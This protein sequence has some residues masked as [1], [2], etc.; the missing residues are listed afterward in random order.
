M[1]TVTPI[2][3][4]SRLD[5]FI[6]FGAAAGSSTCSLPGTNTRGPSREVR[7]EEL[8]SSA[9]NTRLAV[10]ANALSATG[11][12]LDAFERLAILALYVWLVA[13]VASSVVHGGT[14]VNV[15]LLLSEGLVVVFL[16][17]R[18][19]SRDLSR[20][21][22]DWLLA[23][24]A[25]CGP[26]LVRPVGGD[27][28]VAPAVA[29]VLWLT[30]TFIQL[31]AKIALGRSFGCVPAHRGIKR[32]GPYCVV[33]HPMYAGYLLGHI[34]FWLLN[35][36]VGNLLLLAL[37][38]AIQIPRLLAEERLLGRDPGYRQY[39]DKVRY[40]LVPGLF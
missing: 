40:R 36:T 3:S 37:C 31:W 4:T 29:A 16:L 21:P 20:A 10:E 25:T 24:G 15:L 11:R 26:L 30:G 39:A 6:P 34:A 23:V 14:L 8:G 9:A 13:R 12:F 19:P 33:R 28:L 5:P 35:P 18:R 1:S 22:M 27:P 32:E 7:R 38:D 17:A 2:E